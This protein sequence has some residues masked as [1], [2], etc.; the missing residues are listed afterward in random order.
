MP[1]PLLDPTP[2]ILAEL[3][4][5]AGIRSTIEESFAAVKSQVG[6]GQH[7]VRY[8]DFWRRASPSLPDGTLVVQ[9]ICT[10]D[11]AVDHATDSALVG[12]ASTK[13]ND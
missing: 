8:W 10:T 3:V 1:L 11:A 2:L 12:P 5:V 7:Q 4:R 13:P 6:L 9:T